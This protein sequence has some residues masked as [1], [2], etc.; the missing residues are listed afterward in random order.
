MCTL[1][2]SIFF[3]RVRATRMTQRR[4]ENTQAN[5]SHSRLHRLRSDFKNV[6][7]SRWSPKKWWPKNQ[8]P[9]FSEIYYILLNFSR[10][11]WWDFSNESFLRVNCFTI[12]LFQL[13]REKNCTWRREYHLRL[14]FKNLFFVE[15][16]NS[17]CEKSGEILPT[18]V[19][20]GVEKPTAKNFP[21]FSENLTFLA[22]IGLFSHWNC[23]KTTFEVEQA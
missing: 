18:W 13:Y 17:V 3:Q 21:F 8:N 2:P 10:V 1:F 16:F 15:N 9:I 14:N 7:G 22:E 5:L 19:K 6:L 11:F 4:A 23:P 20:D 12:Y